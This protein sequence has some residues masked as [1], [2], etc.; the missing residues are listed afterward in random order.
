[1]LI[2]LEARVHTFQT[3]NLFLPVLPMKHT[4]IMANVGKEADG[5]NIPCNWNLMTFYPQSSWTCVSPSVRWLS[6]STWTWQG[7]TSA[8]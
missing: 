3:P 4:H 7:D 6:W 2:R 5:E 1:M 8:E